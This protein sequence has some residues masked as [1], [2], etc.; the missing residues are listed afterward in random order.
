[1][2]G[3]KYSTFLIERTR[4]CINLGGVQLIPIATTFL[5]ELAIEAHSIKESPLTT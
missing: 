3:E 5:H 2:A 4:L 1:M